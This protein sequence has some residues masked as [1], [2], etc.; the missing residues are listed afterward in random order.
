M[1]FVE[2]APSITFPSPLTGRAVALSGQA[3]AETPGGLTVNFAGVVTGSVLTNADGTFS[4]SGLGSVSATTA[5][6]L[7][8]NTAT[9]V[10]TD[11]APVI[12]PASW[13]STSRPEP[14]ASGTGRS[15]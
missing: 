9:F 15:A 7:V 14:G 13:E 4:P 10:L 11:T 12:G 5:H 8:S 6:G 1:S 2:T 3:T